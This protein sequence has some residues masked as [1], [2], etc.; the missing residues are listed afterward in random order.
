MSYWDPQSVELQELAALPPSDPRRREFEASL[1]M[2]SPSEKLYWTGLLRETDRLY[3]ELSRVPTPPGLEDRL[4]AIARTDRRPLRDRLVNLAFDWRYLV[5]GLV[6]AAIV[7]GACFWFAEPSGPVP[8][9]DSFAEQIADQAVHEHEQP[10]PLQVAGSD[11][12]TVQ[13]ALNRGQV[14]FPVVVLQPAGKLALQ[15]GGACDL[16]G[17]PA[18]YTRWT[19]NGQTYT[20]YQF[21]GRKIGIPARFYRRLEVPRSL[22]HDTHHYSVVIW[23]GDGGQCTWALV[24]E[25]ERAKDMF[26]RAVY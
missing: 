19:G 15:G 11:L 20:L 3:A 8:L 9:P 4:L 12:Q 7:A 6:T 13:A 18:A 22:W 26:S 2:A 14:P 16:D 17:T 5:G 21:D 1:A 10:P 24:L 25:S 23:P